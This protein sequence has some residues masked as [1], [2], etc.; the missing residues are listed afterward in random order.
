M[1]MEPFEVTKRD[2]K[3]RGEME[4]DDDALVAAGERLSAGV[5]GH[6]EFPPA[7]TRRIVRA[8][9]RWRQAALIAHERAE[10]L[11]AE[12]RSRNADAMQLHGKRP[13]ADTAS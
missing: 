7:D 12:I 1:D 8:G 9:L 4:A 10:A 5:T 6:R 3:D 13:N 2:L 11:A